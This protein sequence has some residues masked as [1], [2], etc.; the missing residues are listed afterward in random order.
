MV[1]LD[2]EFITE[3]SSIDQAFCV[4]ISLYVIFELQ[5]GAHNRIIQL[6]YGILLQEPG[7]LTKPLRLL[8]NQWDFLIDK[9]ENR[10][11]IHT[12]TTTTIPMSVQPLTD[13]DSENHQSKS[14]NSSVSSS[15]IEPPLLIAC[16]PIE[17]QVVAL[18]T[19]SSNEIIMCDASGDCQTETVLKKKTTLGRKRLSDP[20]ET[21]ASR[22]K[23][24]KTKKIN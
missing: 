7:A 13:K 9:K 11:D 22:L 12:N 15:P 24:S 10:R 1:F 14:F 8:L 3:M 18:P 4:V 23:R 16:L 6:L 17:E 5:F 21:I 2:Y 20:H 19:E